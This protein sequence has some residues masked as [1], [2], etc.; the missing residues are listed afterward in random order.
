[1]GESDQFDGVFGIS[2]DPSK[3]GVS[4]HNLDSQGKDNPNGLAGWF[5]GNVVVTGDV[6]LTGS[7]CAEDFDIADA[8]V[9]PGT[10][11]AI[12]QNGSLRP[13]NRPYDKKVAG[14][15]S[16]AGNY[17][18]GIVLDKQPPRGNRRPIALVGKVYCKVDAGYLPIEIGDLL[19]SSP[20]LGHAMKAA[21]PFKAFGAVIGKAL[22]PL[23]AG[24]GLIP[25]LIALQ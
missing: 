8:E 11:M 1:V 12:D 14:V 19:T 16:G 13:S 5:G 25:I 6:I 24:Q 2:H 9:G 22:R 7:D 10:V 3:A 17:R 4:G 20:T 15:V 21:D 18:P 23:D